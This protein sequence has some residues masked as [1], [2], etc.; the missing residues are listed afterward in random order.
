MLQK[1]IVLTILA[2]AVLLSAGISVFPNLSAQTSDF[3][4]LAWVDAF[5]GLYGR[6]SKEYAFTEWKGIDWPR[7]HDKYTTDIK[8][9]QSEKNFDAYYLALR[10]YVNEF[11]DGHVRVD[12]L[13]EI[14][15][16]YVGGGFGLAAAKLDD[17]TIIAPWV[18][19]AGLAWAG[20]M[21]N[22]A[23]LLEWNGQPVADAVSQ[24]STVFAGTSATNENLECKKLQYLVRASVG[25]RVE[26]KYQNPGDVAPRSIALTAYNDGG[27]SLKKAYPDSVVSEK[28][29]AMFL[30]IENPD[31]VPQAMVETTTLEGN[32][33]YIKIWGELDADLQQTGQMQ[34]TLDLLR[35]AVQKANDAQATGIILDLRSNIG[36]LDAMA[37]DILGSF[38]ADK[39]LFEY[40]QMYNP[41][42]GKFEI[43]QAESDSEALYIKPAL[44]LFRGK[45]I[46]L[47]NQKCVS[48]CEGIAMGIRNLPNG[49]TLGFYGTNGSFGL[50][51]AEAKMPGE[52]TV[53]WPSGRSLDK[54]REIQLD[55]KDYQGGVSPS[56]RIPM[57]AENATRA[58]RGQDVE[59]EAAVRAILGR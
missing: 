36:G 10:A 32:V 30:N 3:S 7:L 24:V 49:E 20:G 46:A 29:R 51:G 6:M 22:G 18:D 2:A 44:P 28:L 4:G 50:A 58:A 43:Q 23:R 42:T 35:L 13:A 41:A 53:H 19:E 39:T 16:K 38:Y 31:P 40:Q 5:D 59:L 8:K 54:N 14:D 26:V 21:R 34:S 15:N 27:L 11:P 52:V 47:I 33:G 37:A 1:R 56:I 12:N 25:T 55:S 48:S 17:G 45:V 9:A 57:T